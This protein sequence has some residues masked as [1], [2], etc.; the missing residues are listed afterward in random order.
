MIQY[1]LCSYEESGY[2]NY[3]FH[4]NK[5]T[6][7]NHAPWNN[8]NWCVVRYNMETD[9]YS[10]VYAEGRTFPVNILR[11]TTNSSSPL[12]IYSVPVDKLSRP[13]L[14]Y[15]K[16]EPF[17]DDPYETPRCFHRSA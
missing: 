14:H 15:E 2:L 4:N 9:R 6:A 7:L 11:S 16:H 5:M 1:I 12:T 3:S 13:E 10:T 17:I 8:E